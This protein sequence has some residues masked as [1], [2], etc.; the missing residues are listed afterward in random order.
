MTGNHRRLR[1]GEEIEALAETFSEGRRTHGPYASR[2][3]FDCEWKA[4]EAT[5]DLDNAIHVLR[6]EREAWPGRDGALDE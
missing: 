6:S 4:I 1:S 2:R 5:D 3:E